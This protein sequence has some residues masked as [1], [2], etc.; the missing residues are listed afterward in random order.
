MLR[1]IKKILCKIYLVLQAFIYY[2]ITVP[3]DF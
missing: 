3:A 2:I 1:Y